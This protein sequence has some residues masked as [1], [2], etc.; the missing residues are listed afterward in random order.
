MPTSRTSV[1][2][3]NLWKKSQPN[4]VQLPG[5]Y[6]GKSERM[7]SAKLELDTAQ[8]DLAD[9]KANLALVI[10]TKNVPGL[11]D[12][13]KRLSDAEAGYKTAKAMLD[14]ANSAADQDAAAK[15]RVR[16]I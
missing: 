8:K 14:L 11:V 1:N 3:T 10:S 12:I 6:F 15:S 9:Q 5:W 7:A 2:R 4:D 13:E 16:S